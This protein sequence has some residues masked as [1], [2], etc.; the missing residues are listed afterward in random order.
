MLMTWT[1]SLQ[2]NFALS[3]RL[4]YPMIS[5]MFHWHLKQ[6]IPNALFQTQIYIPPSLYCPRCTAPQIYSS[7][8]LQL[9]KSIVLQV[10]RPPILQVPKSAAPRSIVSLNLQLL[11]I[12]SPKT[13]APQK[14]KKF[15]FIYS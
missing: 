9:P 11:Q 10:Y 4:I 1:S 3:S 12:Y 15:F 8:N 14:F 5:Q 2:P 7:P 6:N 13:T